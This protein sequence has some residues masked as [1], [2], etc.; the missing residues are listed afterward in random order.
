M[1]TDLKP[2]CTTGF[3]QCK[4]HADTSQEP[5]VIVYIKYQ[6]GGKNVIFVSVAHD[7]QAGLCILKTAGI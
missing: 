7:R 4:N 6:N 2:P 1:D 3:A 5:S